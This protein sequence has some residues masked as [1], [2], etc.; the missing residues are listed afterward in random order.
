[1]RD[2]ALDQIAA[3]CLALGV[4]RRH[5]SAAERALLPGRSVEPLDLESVRSLIREGGDPLGQA[6]CSSS[7]FRVR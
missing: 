4:D 5:L 2:A 7:H 1:M 6:L 3:T